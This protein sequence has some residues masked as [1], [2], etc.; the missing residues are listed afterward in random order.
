MDIIEFRDYC[1]NKPFVTE[2]FPFDENTLVF[3]VKGKM[4][5]LSG[6]EP[7]TSINLKCDPE[8]ALELRAEYPFVKPG[9]HMNKQ[10]W[11]TVEVSHM[12]NYEL[13]RKLID[14]SYEQVV[15]K[16]PK[17]EREEIKKGLDH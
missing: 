13:L 5:A 3:K 9:F 10:H 8:Y 2:S 12:H 11:N 1:L 17:R 4:F 14:H 6:I 15:A 16:L 7:F